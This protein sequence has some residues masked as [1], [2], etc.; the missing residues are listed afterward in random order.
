MH[1]FF[2]KVDWKN[3]KKV[4]PVFV[5]EL[6]SDVDTKYC[7]NFENEELWIN[8]NEAVKSK[9]RRDLNFKYNTE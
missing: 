1:P 9:Q 8:P 3:I 6:S 5:P 2:A 4:K 7:E